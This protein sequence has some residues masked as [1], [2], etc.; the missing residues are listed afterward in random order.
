[1]SSCGRERRGTEGVGA[2]PGPFPG[3][4]VPREPRALSPEPVGRA[5]ARGK[6]EQLQ[7]GEGGRRA[8]LAQ[9]YLAGHGGRRGP[10]VGVV[11]SRLGHPAGRERLSQGPSPAAW[12]ELPS[13]I[14]TQVWPHIWDPHLCRALTLQ[15][16]RPLTRPGQPRLQA[17]KSGIQ[18]LPPWA[19][20][21]K[22]QRQASYAPRSPITPKPT[23]RSPFPRRA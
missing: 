2:A 14:P 16:G 12:G 19:P 11:K 15:Q 6:A 18:C 4:P 23:N 22:S 7:E 8:T 20:E 9:S 3:P 1:M 5:E 10:E 21:G 13:A 17:E